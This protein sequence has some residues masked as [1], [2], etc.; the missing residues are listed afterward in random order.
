MQPQALRGHRGTFSGW[1]GNKARDNPAT[2]GFVFLLCSCA[3]GKDVGLRFMTPGASGP[4]VDN[5]D[6]AESD[7]KS[8]TWE[9][10]RGSRAVSHKSCRGCA[11]LRGAD[12][13]AKSAQ[14]SP[15][16]RLPT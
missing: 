8:P 15:R 14:T 6:T 10:P 16:R 11:R 9:I 4:R 1:E 2:G 12:H 3:Q 5:K 7:A 13:P